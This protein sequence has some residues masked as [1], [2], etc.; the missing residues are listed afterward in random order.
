MSLTHYIEIFNV[1][2]INVIK[3]IKKWR[4]SSSIL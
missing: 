4:V 1:I 3:I 2:K